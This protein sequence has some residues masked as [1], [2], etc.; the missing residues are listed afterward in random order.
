MTIKMTNAEA[1]ALGMPAPQGKGRRT[2]RAVASGPY[3]TACVECAEVF[4]SRAAEDRH[5]AETRHP[6]YELVLA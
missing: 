5:F 4:F 1:L 2:P 3:A 6:R